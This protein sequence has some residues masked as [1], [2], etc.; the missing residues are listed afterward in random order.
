MGYIFNWV[1]YL[2][3]IAMPFGSDGVLLNFDFLHNFLCFQWIF[4]CLERDFF[5]PLWQM[6]KQCRPKNLWWVFKPYYYSYHSRM[7]VLISRAI[8]EL[9]KILFLWVNMASDHFVLVQIFATWWPKEFQCDPYKG[10]L[11]KNVPKTPDCEEKISEITIVRWELPADHQ[12]IA[13][14]LKNFCSALWPVAKF[15]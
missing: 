9:V 5:R 10:F 4:L 15:G 1:L 13:G 7:L 2:M 3:C 12:N 8:W 11:W 6:P 14:F